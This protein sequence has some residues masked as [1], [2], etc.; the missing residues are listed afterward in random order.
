LFQPSFGYYIPAVRPTPN[1]LFPYSPVALTKRP[2]VV[3]PDLPTGQGSFFFDVKLFHTPHNPN[4]GELSSRDIFRYSLH[5]V[6]YVTTRHR[7]TPLVHPA[8]TVLG[9]SAIGPVSTLSGAYPTALG[10]TCPLFFPKSLSRGVFTEPVSATACCAIL[11]RIFF[12]TSF[13]PSFVPPQ[14]S[15]RQACNCCLSR[16]K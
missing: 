7:T 15:S 8:S 1:A 12:L 11:Q 3:V 16:D 13:P 2:H 5:D 14:R 6:P 10:L 4:A 9:V